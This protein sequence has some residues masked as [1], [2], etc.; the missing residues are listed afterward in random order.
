MDSLADGHPQAG[1]PKHQ[2]RPARAGLRVRRAVRWGRCAPPKHR[3]C[4]PLRAG[5]LARFIASRSCVL[6]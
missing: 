5:R 3:C 1:I 4:H 6:S 2:G